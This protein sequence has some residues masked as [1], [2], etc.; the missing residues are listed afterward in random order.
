MGG[1]DVFPPPIVYFSSV[2]SIIPHPASLPPSL[3]PALSPLLRHYRRH[4]ASSLRAELLSFSPL[5]NSRSTFPP[6][7]LPSFLPPFSPLP[8]RH[9]RASRSSLH[10]AHSYVPS[11]LLLCRGNRLSGGGVEGHRGRNCGVVWW[12]LA[13]RTR[14]SFSPVQRNRKRR[15]R[16][17]EGRGFDGRGPGSAGN[18]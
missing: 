11:L 12:A 1:Q 18:E 4:P 10:G 2:L 17:K 5:S 7:S 14:S 13:V 16:G 3:P 15:S 9:Y 6:P 8:G